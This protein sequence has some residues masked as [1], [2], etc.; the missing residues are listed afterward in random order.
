MPES[1]VSEILAGLAKIE[2]RTVNILA[3]Q[4]RMRDDLKQRDSDFRASLDSFKSE[5]ASKY[6]IKED[7]HPVRN[8][9]YG[10]VGIILT[11]VVISF[12]SFV[13]K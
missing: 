4:A 1:N 12:V 7:F 10:L 3:E 2:E 8:V 13:M 5:V 11:A 6:V 9:V